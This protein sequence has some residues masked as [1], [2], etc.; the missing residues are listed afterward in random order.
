MPVCLSGTTLNW[1]GGPQSPVGHFDCCWSQRPVDANTAR[2]VCRIWYCWSPN[3]TASFDDF[4]QR[5]RCRSLVDQFVPRQPHSVRPLSWI[6]VDSTSTTDVVWSPTGVDPGADMLSSIYSR[7]GTAGGILWTV[8]TLIRWWHPD[9][10]LLST[11]GHRQP[12]ETCCWLC[13]C[14]RWLDAFQSTSAQ[15]IQDGSTVVRFSP[16]T[17]SATFRSVGCWFWSCVTCQMRARSRYFHWR[18]PD[19]AYPSQSDMFEV[20]CCPSTTTKHMLICVK[21][22]DAVA[23]RRWCFP[24]LNTAPQLLPAFRSNSWTCFSLCK[25]PLHGWSSKVVV[26]TTFSRTARITLASNARMHF[27]PAG[28]SSVSLP[29]R[30]CTWLPGLRS[31]AR[32]TPQRTS[33][34]ALF[35]YISAG[36]STHCAF[37][38]WWPQLSNN[39]CTG[40]EQFAG[41]SPVIAVIASFPQ[42]TENRTFCPV[43]QTWL[44]MS[45]CTDYYYVT[46]LFKLIVT[47]P[48]S[49]TS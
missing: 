23:H 39:C 35:D 49:L 42:Q 32:V 46:S 1:D 48:C 13:P 11:R 33:T 34:T 19:D 15:C 31:S 7:S 3:L 28:S 22:H 25:T 38:H 2:P 47:C 40:L 16:S 30:L 24:G 29:P 21:R 4:P 27:V 18:W 5:Q 41:V 44:R 17:K 20:F 8:S 9:L 26:R 6:Q 14:H 36:R 12:T 43:L 10:R 45:H 37:Y